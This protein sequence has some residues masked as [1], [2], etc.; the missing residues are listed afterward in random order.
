L[1]ALTVT[2]L[3]GC[4]GAEKIVTST[5]DMRF[6]VEAV[7]GA[8][9]YEVADLVLRQIYFRAVDPDVDNALGGSS[10]GM[11]SFSASVDLNASGPVDVSVGAPPAGSMPFSPGTYRLDRVEFSSGFTLRD[12]DGPVPVPTKCTD[13]FGD[14]SFGGSPSQFME[15]NDLGPVLLEIAPQGDGSFRMRIDVPAMVALL[16]RQWDCRTT[17]TCPQAGGIPAPCLNR[18]NVPTPL[19]LKATVSFP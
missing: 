15:I 8:G 9:R 13:N 19:Q 4:T 2:I 16:E 6:T 14:L 3:G 12:T 17:G 7:G 11:L 10:L 1:L 18:F 5:G